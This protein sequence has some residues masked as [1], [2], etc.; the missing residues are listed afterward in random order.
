MMPFLMLELYS[1]KKI[2]HIGSHMIWRKSKKILKNYKIDM[3]Y[4]T[5]FNKITYT[6]YKNT[7]TFPF[8]KRSTTNMRPGGK[9]R[10]GL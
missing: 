1:A 5:S 9:T 6:R 2:D 8:L 10:T 3:N 4:D 7:L